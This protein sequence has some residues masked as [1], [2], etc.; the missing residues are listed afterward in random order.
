MLP[1]RVNLEHDFDVSTHDSS[2]DSRQPMK[3][4]QHYIFIVPTIGSIPNPHWWLELLEEQL[5]RLYSAADNIDS[6]F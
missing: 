2:Y 3:N 5:L 1:S 6:P 4:L